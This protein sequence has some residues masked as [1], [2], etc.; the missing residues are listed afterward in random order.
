M[1]EL[2]EDFKNLNMIDR[3]LLIS[4]RY[5]DEIIDL[6]DTTI[7]PNSE[8]YIDKVTPHNFTRVMEMLNEDETI[9]AIVVRA[10]NRQLMLVSKDNSFRRKYNIGYHDYFVVLSKIAYN[11]YNS[12]YA[13]RFI[14]SDKEAPIKTAISRTVKSFYDKAPE[15]TKK[16][17][18]ILVIK[19][20]PNVKQQREDR[21]NAQAGRVLVPS[22]K[23]YKDFINQLNWEFGKR[24]EKFINDRRVNTNNIQEIGEYLMN[25][26][27]LD[28]I[29]VRGVTY[30]K[31]DDDFRV[32]N[33][34][35][36][37]YILY[38]SDELK[39][40]G[41]EKYRL[42]VFFRFD[43]FKPVFLKAVPVDRW[44]NSSHAKLD[45]GNSSVS[46]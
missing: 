8:I 43:G 4:N 25:T 5:D 37:S 18:D 17:W 15:G 31:V 20:D 10:H 32:G 35:A 28:K 36:I 12:H 26:S 23:N 33:K 40:K 38:A 21:K 41:E 11:N 19:K 14:H 7:T 16:K 9:G 13:S 34:D 46:F 45:I 1:M 6:K 29:K 3:T 44:T 22:D 39:E 30:T 2:F 27:K 24:A 42:Y